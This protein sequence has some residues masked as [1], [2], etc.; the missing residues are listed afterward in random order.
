MPRAYVGDMEFGRCPYAG[1]VVDELL[2]GQMW[3]RVGGS[4]KRVIKAFQKVSGTWQPVKVWEK[5]AGTWVPV[6][7]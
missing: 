2:P 5:V 1:A 6:V 4:W 7:M 3:V